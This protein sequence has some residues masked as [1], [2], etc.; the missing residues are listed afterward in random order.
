VS[1][2][3][4]DLD[5]AIKSVIS[6]YASELVTKWV[7]I[8]ETVTADSRGFYALTADGMMPWDVEGLTNYGRDGI[9]SEYDRD[10]ED[11]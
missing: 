6:S 5:Q 4:T 1:D 11:E 9:I 7:C 8:I 10:D 2:L 3:R